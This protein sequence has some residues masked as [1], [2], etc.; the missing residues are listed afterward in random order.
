MLSELVPNMSRHFLYSLLEHDYERGIEIM[1]TIF[2]LPPENVG[3]FL[4]SLCN[5]LDELFYKL[6]VELGGYNKV[7]DEAIKALKNPREE[8][9]E[10]FN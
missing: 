4:S 2:S 1:N 8:D 5:G 7:M 6:E 10:E 3:E 9:M